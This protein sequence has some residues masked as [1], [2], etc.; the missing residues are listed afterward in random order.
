[1]PVKPQLIS[2]VRFFTLEIVNHYFL[3]GHLQVLHAFDT[4]PIFKEN[5]FLSLRI[6]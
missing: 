1:M 3:H 5:N 2:V 6:F 4:Q